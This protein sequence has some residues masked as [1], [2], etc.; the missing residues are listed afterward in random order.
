M[1][2]QIISETKKTLSSTGITIPDIDVELHN[3]IY[4]R[5]QEVKTIITN[6]K[7]EVAGEVEGEIWMLQIGLIY[8]PPDYNLFIPGLNYCMS[9]LHEKVYSSRSIFFFKQFRVFMN[10]M[11]ELYTKRQHATLEIP[12]VI[13]LNFFSRPDFNRQNMGRFETYMDGQFRRVLP[14]VPYKLNQYGGQNIR[15]ILN[16]RPETITI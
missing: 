13:T 10:A 15:R 14:M 16:I 11:N 6:K 8:C 1:Q 5:V 12:P 7:K 9:I 2:S 4:S 3:Q